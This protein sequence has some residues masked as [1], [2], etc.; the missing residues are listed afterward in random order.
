MIIIVNAKVCCVVPF[1][2]CRLKLTVAREVAGML[3]GKL[4]M[5]TAV[6]GG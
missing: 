6:A 3:G 5:H 2:T 4:E 1:R